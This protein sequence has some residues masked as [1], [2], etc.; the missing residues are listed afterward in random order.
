MQA[1]PTGLLVYARNSGYQVPRYPVKIVCANGDQR[2][3]DLDVEV[4]I[5]QSGSGGWGKN[6]IKY[7]DTSGA[8]VSIWSSTQPGKTTLKLKTN[9][10]YGII[11]EVSAG[12]TK[13]QNELRFKFPT[14]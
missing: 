8:E 2:V 1:S 6:E 4:E 14:R 13:F 9:F 11:V 7:I 10:K 3:E 5:V 12:A